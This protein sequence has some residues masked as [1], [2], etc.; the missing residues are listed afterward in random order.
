MGNYDVET[1]AQYADEETQRSTLRIAKGLL[2]YTDTSYINQDRP[3]EITIHETKVLNDSS[4]VV[5]YTKSTPIKQINLSLELRKRD[6]RWYAHDPIQTNM[7]GNPT[8]PSTNIKRI[9]KHTLDSIK[10][11]RNQISIK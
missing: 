10:S 7:I 1:A 3:A 6:N 4:A 11:N 9:D 5:C 2:E 8:N